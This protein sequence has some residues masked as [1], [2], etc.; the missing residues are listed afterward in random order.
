MTTTLDTPT[1]ADAAGGSAYDIADRWLTAFGTA[2][3]GGDVNA[4]DKLFLADGWWRDLLAFTWDLRTI[5]GTDAIKNT[6]A[7]TLEQV[8]PSHFQLAEGKP[9]ELLEA[10]ENTR[11]VQGFFD[12]E[13]AVARGRGFF[14]LMPD[15]DAWK[16][17]TVLTAMEELKGHEER[18]GH[19]RVKGVNH[20]EQDRRTS[21]LDRRRM[22]Q[23]FAEDE[24]QV[25]VVGA[26]Q[27]GLSIA[28]RLGQ[29]DVDT[30]VI[31]R[32]ERIG[33]SWRNRYRSLV[34]HDP[35]WYD[36]M[37]YLPFPK[38]WPV[39]T[40]KD[41]LADWFE[42]YA[43][44]MELN[45]WTQT[46][47]L[48]ATYDDATQTWTARVRREEGTERELHPHH[49][50]L[51]TGMS[52]VPKAPQI[53]G[54]EVYAGVVTHS[55][56]HRSGQDYA[57]KKAIVVGS[58]NSGHDIAHDFYEQG[59]DVTMVQRSS[60][61][62]MTSENGI[63]TLFAGTYEEGGPPTE[64]ADLIF[65]SIPYPV[66]A[67]IHQGATQQI[68]E[69]DRD[70]LAGLARAGFK[71]DYG[72]DGSGLF[73]KYLRRGGGY[74]IDVGASRLIAD[75]KIKIKQ[76][77]EIERFTPTGVQFTDGTELP[78]DIVVL[79]TGYENMR[80][81]ARAILGDAVADRCTPVWGLDDEGELRA[82][83]R[84]SGHDGFWFMGGN[85]HQS[86]HY[87]KFLALRIKAIE[88]GLLHRDA[89]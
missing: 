59:A 37:A 70:L 86:R 48:G 39:F 34:L 69:L 68:A 12:F 78:A 64:D 50:V 72:E 63:A 23:D 42:S 44:G 85:L 16:G 21:W 32:N 82:I 58:C 88:E 33:D 79:A 55:S 61:Y 1:T 2:L 22:K 57:G 29:L 15:G 41:K 28:A 13:T 53:P 74:Y 51:A 20:G 87:S 56:G 18:L 45:V 24:P 84:D 36:H 26:G 77:V 49:I 71:I 73:M 4:V 25:L 43:A 89:S 60:T 14:R 75:G 66:L 6:L 47:L 65:A 35:V 10:D 30:L 27:A 9:P 52:G 62:V 67:Q 5:H 46:E 54:T 83:W 80:E 8:R 76:G 81:S 7:A 40:P 17:W 3:A 38:H 31:E 11:W 19:N